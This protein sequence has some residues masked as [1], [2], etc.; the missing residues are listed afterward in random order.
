MAAIA[1]LG[2]TMS[3]DLPYTM[4]HRDWNQ[5]RFFSTK[6]WKGQEF[7]DAAKYLFSSRSESSRFGLFFFLWALPKIFPRFPLVPNIKS[8]TY[9][10]WYCIQYIPFWSTIIH[11]MPYFQKNWICLS[12]Q[13]DSVK[14]Y[15]LIFPDSQFSV[16]SLTSNNTVCNLSPLS[17]F[18]SGV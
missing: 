12:L 9:A 11:S 1:P 7:V 16:S 3:L 14:I 13:I 15:L 5:V 17:P 18:Y 8:P 10:W 2:S 6:Y 4:W